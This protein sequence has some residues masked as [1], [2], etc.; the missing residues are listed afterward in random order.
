MTRS[1][2]RTTGLTGGNSMT[3]SSK[4]SPLFRIPYIMLRAFMKSG[5]GRALLIAAYR[6]TPGRT[7]PMDVP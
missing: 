3:G 7:V 4:P 2:S 6:L 1:E 5:H